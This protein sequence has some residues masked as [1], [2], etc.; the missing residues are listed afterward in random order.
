[1]RGLVLALALLATGC[2][3]GW[4]S[5]A[6]D[7]GAYRATRVAP[8]LE[9]RLAAAQRYLADRPDGTFRPEVLAWFIRAEEAFYASKKGSRTGFAAYLE[10]LPTGPHSDEAARRVAE[11]DSISRE[12]QIDRLAAEVEARVAGPGAA[13][14]TRFRKELDAWLARF[15]DRGVFGVPMSAAKADLVIPFSLSL[16]SPRCV[17]LD[18]GDPAAARAARRCAKLI[19]LPY[20]VEGPGGHEPREATLEVTVLEDAFG[21]PLEVTL[22][23]PELFLRLEETYRIRPAGSDD[24]AAAGARAAAFVRRA[25]ARTVSDARAC[26]QPVQPPAALRLGCDGIQIE[27]FPTAVAGED[28]LIVIVPVGGRSGRPGG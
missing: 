20:E 25:F 24:R 9:G 10:A 12:S 28:D 18:P 4:A 17:L 8:T 11:L 27:V 15:L 16:P 19:E 14:R 3:T 23:G 22:G 5:S 7:F 26:A 13:A 6:N 2:G 1:M 21:A